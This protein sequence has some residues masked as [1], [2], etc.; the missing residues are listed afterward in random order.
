MRAAYGGRPTLGVRTVDLPIVTIHPHECLAYVLGP[1][2]VIDGDTLDVWIDQDFKT[3]RD[4]RIRL[5][6]CNAREKTE[7]GGP[8]AR[9]HLIDLLWPDNASWEAG[10]APKPVKVGLI[11]FK[12]DDY[13]GRYDGDI[14]LLNGDGLTGVSLTKK[15]ILDGYAAPWNGRGHAPVP[16]WPIPEATS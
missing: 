13:G 11:T 16:P 12:V 14:I 8:E 7:P 2:E 15:M 4:Q 3:W 1:G 10:T 9:Q 5:I 6:K